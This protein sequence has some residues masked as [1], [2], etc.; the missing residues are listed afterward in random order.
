MDLKSLNLFLAVYDARN[1][2]GAANKL[3]MNQPAVSKAVHRIEQELGIELF[4]REPRGVAPTQ[5]ADILADS[6]REVD[7]TLTATFRRI[8]AMRNATEGE[9]VVGA[10]GTWQEAILPK[11]VARVI[12]RRPGARI[13]IL[14]A[15]PEDLLAALIKG[16]FDL[17]LAPLDLPDDIAGKVKT[18][19][20][21]K[22]ELAVIGRKDH[23]LA[24]KQK[25]SLAELT[26]QNWVLPPGKFIRERFERGF[27][28]AGLEPPL[29]S[30]ECYDSSCLFQ[31]VEETDIL[32]FV[33]EIRL[34]Q[35]PDLNLQ[36]MP[37]NP[38]NL[39]RESGL[40]LRKTSY[41]PPL[42]KHLIREVE[43]LSKIEMSGR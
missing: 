36:R 28:T 27:R 35:R 2:S 38:L 32:T 17:G 29:P 30:I 20:L 5:F 21:I 12:R 7:T 31:I 40:I 43:A 1:I 39:E 9:I 26:T 33:A 4:E 16:K 22:T 23:P 18:Q 34:A 15:Q 13:I 42:A 6:A 10:G 8:D 14:P 19:C 24:G 11:A 37:D 41:V 3:G 25:L